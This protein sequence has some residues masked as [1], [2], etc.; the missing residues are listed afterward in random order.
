MAFVCMERKQDGEQSCT[1]GGGVRD[2]GGEKFK[3]VDQR[4]VGCSGHGD[5]RVKE[6]RDVSD[7]L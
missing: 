2:V 5:E 1:G 7:T 3:K 4:R 6:G